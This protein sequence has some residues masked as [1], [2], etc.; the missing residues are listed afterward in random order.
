MMKLYR[1]TV[2]TQILRARQELAEAFE[3]GETQRIAQISAAID[4][5]Q[6]EC[7]KT[8]WMENAS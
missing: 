8:G 5:L 6:L 2:Y 4:R 3:R 1:P 7:W